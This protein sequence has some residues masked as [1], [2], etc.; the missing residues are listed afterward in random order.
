LRVDMRD[1]GKDP[2]WHVVVDDGMPDASEE[3]RILLMVW[4]RSP[5]NMLYGPLVVLSGRHTSTHTYSSDTTRG[6]FSTI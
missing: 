5:I 4:A 3:T 1:K 6:G 2:I